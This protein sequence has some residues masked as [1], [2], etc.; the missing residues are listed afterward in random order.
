MLNT[1]RQEA[2]LRTY[3]VSNNLILVNLPARI[4]DDNIDALDALRQ[5]VHDNAI[6]DMGTISNV[7]TCAEALDWVKVA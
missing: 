3:R 2:T 7:M 4:S 6:A 5:E 1:G